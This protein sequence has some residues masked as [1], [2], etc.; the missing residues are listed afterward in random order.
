M[1]LVEKNSPAGRMSVQNARQLS[2]YPASNVGDHWEFAPI[3]GR[4]Y[5][6]SHGR[7]QVPHRCVEVRLLLRIGLQ[8]LPRRTADQ[9]VIAC[10]P[11][12][13][14]QQQPAPPVFDKGIWTETNTNPGPLRAGCVAAQALALRCVGEYARRR[15]HKDP[16][17]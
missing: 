4:G 7:A 12:L 13:H 14:G 17:A 2:S 11:I 10:L 5:R 9:L 15:L 3:I 6:R 16:R 8:E 1:W